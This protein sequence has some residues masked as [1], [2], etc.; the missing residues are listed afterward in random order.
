MLPV[1]QIKGSQSHYLQA[2]LEAELSALKAQVHPHFLFNTF[3]TLYGI[4]LQFPDRTP[5]LIMKVSQL[6]RYQLESNSKQ[7]VS[8]EDELEFINSYVQLQKERVGYR[9]DLTFENKVD[10]E[11]TYKISP[12]LLIAFIENAFKHSTNKKISNAI[13][14]SI[15]AGID[16]I[17]F[18]CSNVY[19]GPGANTK[20]QSGLGLELT[21]SRLGLLYPDNY[22]LDIDKTT[23]RFT[24]NLTIN[25]HDD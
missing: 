2:A 17:K 16:K 6:M 21:Q 11:Y 10:N 4:S 14:I 18:N 24:I 1:M 3:N 19:D 9:C 5:D 15:S 25:L 23:D 7:C 12:M 13:T 22:T 20:E 8:L